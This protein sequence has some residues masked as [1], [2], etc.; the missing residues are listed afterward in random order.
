MKHVVNT[1]KKEFLEF[2]KSMKDH[3]VIL[4]TL[5][6][7]SL[8]IN[9]HFVTR[10]SEERENLTSQRIVYDDITVN[11]LNAYEIVNITNITL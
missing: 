2:Y 8:E 3:P 10:A 5:F 7:E 4:G 9:S 11:D 6:C 1:Y